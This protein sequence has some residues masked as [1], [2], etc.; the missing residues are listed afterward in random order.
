MTMNGTRFD[1]AARGL[2]RAA[3]RRG[4]LAGALGVISAQMAT[5]T[6][7][8]KRRTQKNRKGERAEDELLG[9]PG[10]QIGG[11]WEE[12][13]EICHYDAESGEIR[14]TAVPLPSL[15][16]YLNAGDTLYIDCCVDAECPPRECATPS[17]CIEGACMYDVTG[18]APCV[19]ADGLAG[20]CA[21]NGTCVAGAPVEAVPYT[22]VAPAPAA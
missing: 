17:G 11:I 5:S 1:A 14:I 2:A 13:I 3:S 4:L 7:E 22:E 10:S 6:L 9:I 15:P 16:D 20:V 12:T 18:G 19:L 8:A 21:K